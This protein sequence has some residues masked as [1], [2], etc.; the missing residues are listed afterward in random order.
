MVTVTM[1]I[2][3]LMSDS[4]LSSGVY[5]VSQ[6]YHLMVDKPGRWAIPLHHDG[7]RY[8]SIA[9]GNPLHRGRLDT[10]N[11]QMAAPTNQER[12]CGS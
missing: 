1:L 3:I 6:A 5:C 11:Q 12:G 8:L 7:Q 2:S 4:P 9:R 10:I